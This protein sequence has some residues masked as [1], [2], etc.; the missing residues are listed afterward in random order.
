ML[1]QKRLLGFMLRIGAALA[2]FIMASPAVS[3]PIEWVTVGSPNVTKDDT[4]YGAVGYEFQMAKYE[5][6]NAQ[7]VEFLNAVADKED[8]HGLYSAAMASSVHGGI[9]RQ[10]A[11]GSYSYSLKAGMDNKP[12]N[13][14][15]FYDT[16]RFANWLNNGQGAGDTESGAYTLGGTNPVGVVR[17]AGANIFLPSEDEWYKAAYYD[18]VSGS[19]F[20]YAA[21]SDVAMTCSSPGLSLNAGNCNSGSIPNVGGYANSASPYGTFDQGGSLWELTE[22]VYSVSTRIIRGGSYTNA[23]YHL[24][25]I[26]RAGWNADFTGEHPAV[27]FRLMAVVPEPGTATLVSIGLLGLGANRKLRAS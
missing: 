9:A 13:Y 8:V 19:F 6:T 10:G 14:V 27:G 11:L 17:N 2:I 5:T 1:T 22:T 23:Y 4:G 3:A 12:V 21:G 24:S 20:D 15:S 16:L 26:T 18:A 25:S 7:Y